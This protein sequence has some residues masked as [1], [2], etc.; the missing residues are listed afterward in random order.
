MTEEQIEKI[1]KHLPT[2]VLS[3]LL[4]DSLSVSVSR[5]QLIEDSSAT[6]QTVVV[7]FSW[8]TKGVGDNFDDYINSLSAE[9]HLENPVLMQQPRT[10][11]EALLRRLFGNAIPRKIYW[12][13]LVECEGDYRLNENEMYLYRS[14]N[15]YDRIFLG[16]GRT[17][18][19]S[20]S[21]NLFNLSV[22][23]GCSSIPTM[24]EFNDLFGFA[25]FAYN[26]GR[27]IKF[28]D[29]RNLREQL[30][31]HISPIHGWAWES[32]LEEYRGQNPLE[33]REIMAM[34]P[35]EIEERRRRFGYGL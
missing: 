3:H 5:P 34:T 27:L 33:S 10:Y 15:G 13:Q 20:D 4:K 9:R 18:H 1:K 35:M 2:K 22:M 25:H 17:V 31:W 19:F 23:F 12:N 6:V 32:R 8:V 21:D 26:S 7:G 14:G 24:Q 16:H 11:G 29:I 28:Y 30:A